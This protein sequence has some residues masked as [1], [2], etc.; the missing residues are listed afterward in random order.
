MLSH[1]MAAR[2]IERGSRPYLL[3]LMLARKPL[4][5]SVDDNPKGIVQI[6]AV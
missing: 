2:E 3:L 6:E 1:H 4:V 5:V